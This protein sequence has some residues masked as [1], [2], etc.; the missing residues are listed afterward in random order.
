MRLLLRLAASASFIFLWVSN[1][2]CSAGG[3]GTV[4]GTNG[5]PTTYCCGA[6]LSAAA[7]HECCY[8]DAAALAP[9]DAAV[10]SCSPELSVKCPAP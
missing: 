7:L 4:A 6:N 9:I 1:V 10:A 5:T 3:A 8:P 2:A